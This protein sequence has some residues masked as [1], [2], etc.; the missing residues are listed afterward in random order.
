M[1]IPDYQDKKF[2]DLLTKELGLGTSAVF[3]SC[4]SFAGTEIFDHC[5]GTVTDGDVV[6]VL[7]RCSFV[8][9]GDTIIL[10]LDLPGAPRPHGTEEEVKKA[11]MDPRKVRLVGVCT[12]TSRGGTPVTAQEPEIQVVIIP[13]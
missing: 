7:L 1:T 5:I 2:Q 11:G 13:Y 6:Y 10:N 3:S 9:S 8:I 4:G 12:R